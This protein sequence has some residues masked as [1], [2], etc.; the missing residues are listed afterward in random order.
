MKEDFL[1]CGSQITYW[2]KMK[3][4]LVEAFPDFDKTAAQ[5]REK[6]QNLYKT[7]RAKKKA[8]AQTE[9]GKISWQFFN[10]IDAEMGDR[11]GITLGGMTNTG[12][13]NDTTA[14]RGFGHD[15]MND[16]SQ[17]WPTD[18]ADSADRNGSTKVRGKKVKTGRNEVL[19]VVDQLLSSTDEAMGPRPSSLITKR[20]WWSKTSKVW[21][22]VKR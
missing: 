14:L 18:R 6:W 5:V 17:V 21:L 9:A 3:A 15:K 19:V 8:T 11:N 22:P 20:S 13:E 7:Y 2:K 4:A 10:Q 16:P 12:G 1:V